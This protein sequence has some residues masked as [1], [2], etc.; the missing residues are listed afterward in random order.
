MDLLNIKD[1]IEKSSKEHQIEI[2]KI[3]LEN[4]VMVNE[5]NNGIF[6]N[7]SNVNNNIILKLQ[8]YLNYIAEQEKT[9]DT[10][11]H[12]KEEYK[13]TFFNKESSKDNNDLSK[14]NKTISI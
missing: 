7:L 12:T 6:I 8:N 11:E 1:T 4:K 14:D 2:L 5:N 9:L 10:F 13:N 3:L